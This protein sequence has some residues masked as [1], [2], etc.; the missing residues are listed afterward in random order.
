MPG[1]EA[2]GVWVGL[3]GLFLAA[4]AFALPQS[5]HATDVQCIGTSSGDAEASVI[6]V[7]GGPRE[8]N[9]VTAG[10]K[11]LH[12]ARVIDAGVKN[13]GKPIGRDAD[14]AFPPPLSFDVMNVSLGSRGDILY[15]PN[16]KGMRQDGFTKL[17]R[18]VNVRGDGGAGS[19]FLLGHAGIDALRGEVGR[20]G[21]FGSGGADSLRGGPGLDVLIGG[22]GND[23]LMGE[24]G[25]DLILARDHE[26]DAIQCGAGRDL[27]DVDGADDVAANCEKKLSDLIPLQSPQGKLLQKLRVT[28]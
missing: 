10:S 5:A 14:C 13:R 12:H 6:Q 22:R 23:L 3:A 26:A 2:R 9:F 21:L 20:D 17:E 11:G 8:H 7:T 27:Y 1:M 19:D 16:P 28:K 25:R 4:S 15:L 18:H 24:A